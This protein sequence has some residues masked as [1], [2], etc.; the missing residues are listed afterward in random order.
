ME[1]EIKTF[2]DLAEFLKG[3]TISEVMGYDNGDEIVIDSIV[4]VDG[5]QIE[6]YGRGDDAYLGV[7][8]LWG[9]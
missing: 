9:E 2:A 5:Y 4:T 7:I 1:P 8:T 6:L 3:K